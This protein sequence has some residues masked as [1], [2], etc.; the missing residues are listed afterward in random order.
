MELISEDPIKIKFAHG[1][2]IGAVDET[3]GAIAYLGIPYAAPPV[4]GLRFRPPQLHTL[5]KTQNNFRFDARFIKQKL[6]SFKDMDL[7]VCHF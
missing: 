6:F 4:E 5:W 2:V 1:E 7:D 3:T